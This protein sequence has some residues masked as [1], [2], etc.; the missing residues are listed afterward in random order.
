MT[1]VFTKEKRSWLMGR[2]KSCDTKPEIIVRS[3]LHRMGFRFRIN[4]A[5]LTG[6]PDIVLPK[7]KTV[8]FVHGCFWHRHG[9]SCPLTTTPKSRTEFWQDKFDRNRRRDRRNAAALRRQGWQVVTVWECQVLKD[10]AKVATRLERILRGSRTV[11]REYQ[12]PSKRELLTAAE[13]KKKYG[14]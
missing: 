4:R 11:H 10:P 6:R 13:R 1:D 3:L 14:R 12:I 2:I 9:A 7:Y 5:D 8:I